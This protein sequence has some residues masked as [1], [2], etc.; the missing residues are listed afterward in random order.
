M[1]ATEVNFHHLFDAYLSNNSL[2]KPWQFSPT[3]PYESA[4]IFS[5][6]TTTNESTSAEEV[7]LISNFIGPGRG[8]LSK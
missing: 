5:K 4:A 6:R 2:E 8:S 1:S 3:I 7:S